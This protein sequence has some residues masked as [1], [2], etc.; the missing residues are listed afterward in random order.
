MQKYSDELK[1]HRLDNTANIFPVINNLQFSGVFRIGAVLYEEVQPAILE[2]ALRQVLPHF[3]VFQVQLRT[4]IFWYYMESNR[5]KPCIEEEQFYPCR[6]I[7]RYENHSYPFRT[8]YYRNKIYLEIFH[9]L[10]DGFGAIQFMKELTARYLR[11]AHPEDF[12]EKKSSSDSH[13]AFSSENSSSPDGADFPLEN[14]SNVCEDSYLKY[15]RK[16]KVK[17]YKKSKAHQIRQPEL[18]YPKSSVIHGHLKINTVKAAA[19][20]YQVSITQ[21]LAAVLVYTIYKEYL[22][23]ENRDDTICL[24]IPVNLRQFFPSETTMNF[25]SI[26]LAQVQFEKNRSL[27]FEEVLRVL[28]DDFKRQAEPAWLEQQISYNVSNEKNLFIRLVPLPVKAIGVRFLYSRSAKSFTTTLSNLGI[29]RMKPEYE[30]Y[31]RNF[32]FIMGASQSQPVKCVAVSF[33]DEII[34]TISTV[35]K[36]SHL[37]DAFWKCLEEDGVE[38]TTEGNGIHEP[39]EETPYPGIPDSSGSFR[40]LIRWYMLLTLLTGAGLTWY[41]F[42]HYNGMGWSVPVDGVI[43]YSWL[44]LRFFIRFNIN[45]AAR[46]LSH[47]LAIEILWII[48]DIILGYGGQSLNYGF[49][50][51]LLTACGANLF[52]MLNDPMNRLG[53]FMFQI[54]YAVIGLITL[55]LWL[56]GLITHPFPG[57]LALAVTLFILIVGICLSP[58]KI[59]RET[60]R[61]FH[62]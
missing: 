49:P 39:P 35:W 45:P 8:G 12:G 11:L 56:T 60:K 28:T 46:I 47:T 36:N 17:G 10:T 13:T 55:P 41:N 27:T 7:R 61:R 34:F 40:L 62:F 4:G 52:L 50:A 3:E 32:H 6:F 16:Q 20:R 38:L 26:A 1:W 29:I 21:Y 22:S 42:T 58:G 33:R 24:N 2:K 15:Y 57:I 48:T 59:G 51:L 19:S 5:R 53:Y 9:A 25:F 18:D 43:L 23:G 37:E 30:P 14:I 44:S 31:I 54:L